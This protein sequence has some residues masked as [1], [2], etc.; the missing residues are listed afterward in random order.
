MNEITVS[1]TELHLYAV[2]HVLD[3]NGNELP[4]PAVPAWTSSDLN[5][6]EPAPADDGMSAHLIVRG[7][8]TA[9]ILVETG[10]PRSDIIRGEGIVHV[11]DTV[12]TSIRVDLIVTEI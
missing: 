6:I 4:S 12:P 9:T 7:R 1:S 10:V 5:V 8:G 3:E 11:S 2:A